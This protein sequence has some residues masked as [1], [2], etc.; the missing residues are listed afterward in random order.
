VL[1][2]FL[3]VGSALVYIS[4]FN[5]TPVT[6]NLGFYT[7]TD[8]PLFYVIIASFL[9]GIVLSYLIS[10][11]HSIS[12]F[13]TLR[14]KN[15]EIKDNKN[16]I[17]EAELNKQIQNIA[18]Q[19]HITFKQL[20]DSLQRDNIDFENYKNNIRFQI[21]RRTIFENEIRNS[22]SASISDPELKAEFQKKVQLEWNLLILVEKN[23]PQ[24]ENKIRKLAELVNNQQLSI[25]DLQKQEH[26][27]SLG[28]VNASS[29]QSRFREAL[30]G[31]QEKEAVG[32]I[33]VNNTLHLLIIEK[34]RKGSEEQFQAMKD[35]LVMEHQKQQ[36][37]EL[38]QAWVDRK[39]LETE[40]VINK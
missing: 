33:L 18:A 23:S 4:K 37:D 36:V 34:T 3:V 22:S 5:F 39:K 2:L 35:E 25:E 15:K 31:K 28:W 9:L 27:D 20:R 17:T 40:L 7:V 16:E 1:I 10:S 8:V 30:K 21:E 11:A 38:F 26:L 12:N 32:P 13:F 6:V 29:L 24:A 19:H 14:G